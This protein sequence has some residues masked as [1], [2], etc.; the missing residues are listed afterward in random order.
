ME[1]SPLITPPVSQPQ[2]WP[3]VDL[4]T[5]GS[6]TIVWAFATDLARLGLHRARQRLRAVAPRGRCARSGCPAAR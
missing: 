5:G 3:P 2:P 6:V 1:P 4:L